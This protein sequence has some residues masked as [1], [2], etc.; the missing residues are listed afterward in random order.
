V[1]ARDRERARRR[2]AELSTPVDVVEL[3]ALAEHADVV[4]ECAPAAV[5]AEVAGPAVESGRTLVTLSVGALLDHEHLIGRAQET[6]AQIIVPSGALLGL[7]AVRAAAQGDIQSVRMVTRKP[8]RGLAG[9]PLVVER[10]ID[11][12]RLETP[13]RLFEGNARDAV[14]G[15]PANVNVAAALGLAGLGPQATQLEIW[16]DPAVER[17]IHH[18]EVVAD[19]ARF[20]MTIENVPSDDNPRTG[21]IVALSV[22]A[23]LK[24]MIAP[25]RIGA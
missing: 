6:G 16:A 17:N 5:F 23:T 15:F 19:S 25:L 7:D 8:P 9:A 2:V 4:V 1:S 14:K 18:I 24:A 12:D 13:L 22:V 11:L 10:G 20:E 21:R 3:T